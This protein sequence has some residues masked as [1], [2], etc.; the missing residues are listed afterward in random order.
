MA[1]RRELSNLFAVS[2]FAVNWAGRIIGMRPVTFLVVMKPSFSPC[3]FA[4]LLA[5][6]QPVM[7]GVPFNIGA[8]E[9]QLD[10]TLD[11]SLLWSTQGPDDDLIGA[12]NGGRGLSTASDD[13]R[14]NY[15]SGDSVSR[16]FSG[17]TALELRYQD[18]G[19]YV[20][21]RYWYDFALQDDDLPFRQ[22]DNSGR[23]QSAKSSGGEWL[24]AFVYQRYALEE[25]PGEVRVGRQTLNWG[26]GLFIP[27]ALNELNPQQASAYR[28]PV[29]PL[30]EGFL[31]VNLLHLSQALS[32]RWELEGFVQ[33]SRAE[34]VPENCSTFF[35]RA[36]YLAQGCADNL[37]LLQTQQ[38]VAALYGQPALATLQ[39]LGVRWNVPDEGVLVQR[40]DDQ[41][42]AN[43]GQFGLALHYFAEPLDTHFGLYAL[44]VH[45]RQAYMGIQAPDQATYS[46]AQ[47]QGA[48]A[49]LVVAGNS[50]YFMG[51]PEDLQTYGLSFSSQLQLGMVW[52]GELSYRPNAPLQLSAVDLLSAP[53]TP[54]DNSQ[55]PLQLAPGAALSG[56]RRK[57]ISQL[58]TSLSQTFD[59]VMGAQHMTLQGEVA[60]VQV[61]GLESRNEARYGRDPVYGPGS[62]PGN[63]C[64]SRNTDELNAA[65]APLNNASR[66]CSGDGF[67][68]SSAWG[69]RARAV[70]EYQ[71]VLPKLTLK[72]HLG[73][74]QDVAGYGP[75][76]LFSEGA[77]AASIGLNAEYQNIYRA[78]LAYSSFFGGDFNT[79]TDRDFL[80]FSLGVSI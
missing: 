49:P 47:G 54:L 61:G 30:G 20:R 28:Q 66:Y 41:D 69:Y 48:L 31:P 10:T 36:D 79:R 76:G 23:Q 72:P 80:L 21:G 45:S 78:S 16:Q 18:S 42:A 70:W 26:E 19:A 35:S 24:E 3:L 39:V 51:Y 38:Q 53:Q 12:N 60:L 58:Q 9:A 71:Q 37:A 22:I 44:H 25:Q 13:A 32:E 63:G 40:A 6:Y 50:Q 33:L 67:V 1:V 4:L 34:D 57:D 14:L 75:D 52:A 59:Q 8:V 64:V 73:W 68:T 7:A 17:S 29:T 77:K 65:G 74:A 11:Y 15:A 55:S 5:V 2:V 62:L 43:G 46:T 56:Y 27:N